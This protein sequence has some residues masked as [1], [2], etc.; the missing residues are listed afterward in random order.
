MQVD[1]AWSKLF[2]ASTIIRQV[3]FL[4]MIC[5]L[6]QNETEEEELSA[7]TFTEVVI[8]QFV[9]SLLLATALTVEINNT[10]FVII[11]IT[12]ILIS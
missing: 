8:C 3:K 12:L 5:N 7:K 2:P 10:D 4:L 11:L 9:L 1:S 6:G